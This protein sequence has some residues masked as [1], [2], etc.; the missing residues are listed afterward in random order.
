MHSSIPATFNMALLFNNIKASESDSA[1]VLSFLRSKNIRD[2]RI[3]A[4]E[5]L[6]KGH[7][8]AD[9][10]FDLVHYLFDS[11][12]FHQL[13]NTNNEEDVLQIKID[14][15]N[16][17][18]SHFK[19]DLLEEHPHARVKSQNEYSTKLRSYT[20]CILQRSISLHKNMDEFG[21]VAEG[22]ENFWFVVDHY[23]FVNKVKQEL[24]SLKTL[25]ANAE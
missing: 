24:N 22:V 4:D 20:E 21:T 1:K 7:S 17:I 8:F 2:Y 9:I 14:I 16:D 13:F 11:I 19:L 15:Y 10:S 12:N 23:I 25:R 6:N 3:S 5:S 18:V